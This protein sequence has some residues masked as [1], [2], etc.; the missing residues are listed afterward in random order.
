MWRRSHA[1]ESGCDRHGVGMARETKSL[2]FKAR[3]GETN[4]R[5]TTI[6]V[7]Y[8]SGGP[9]SPSNYRPSCSIPILHK[10]F[11]QL[12][13]KRLQPTQDDKPLT[14]QSSH[15]A[16]PRQTT[17]TRSSNSDREHRVA[18]AAVGRSH[19]LQESLRHSGAQQCMDGLEGARHR[20][21]IH[22]A[23]HK[24]LLPTTS[25]SAH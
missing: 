5:D 14:K 24:A 10:L 7:T 17:F 20:G 21:T 13:F 9:A 18:P 8:R 3:S 19:R 23:T 2:V 22:T 11:S 15:R 16:T 6:K 1:V 4:W 12:L 25:I